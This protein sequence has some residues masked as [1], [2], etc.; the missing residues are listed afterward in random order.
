MANK[1]E[2]RIPFM[3]HI[4]S[5]KHAMV[6]IMIDEGILSTLKYEYL[7]LTDN[8]EVYAFRSEEDARL[9]VHTRGWTYLGKEVT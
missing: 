9:V 2:R 6:P 1:V 3:I 8:D 4:R 5:G 7:C